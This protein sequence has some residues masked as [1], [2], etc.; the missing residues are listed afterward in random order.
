MKEDKYLLETNTVV[1][2]S[3]SGWKG[4][5]VPLYEIRILYLYVDLVLGFHPS[6]AAT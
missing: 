5:H 2:W 1:S 6:L 3:L 4:L